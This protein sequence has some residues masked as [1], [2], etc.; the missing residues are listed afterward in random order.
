MLQPRIETMNAEKLGKLQI[1]RLKKI[2]RKVFRRQRFYREKMR[3]LGLKPSDIRDKKDLSK[4]PF[5]LKN[6]LRTSYP[7][8]AIV[9]SRDR[10]LELHASSGT[11]GKPTLIA[12]TFKDL[13]NWSELMARSLAAA[14]VTKNDVIHVSY[15]YHMF[16]GG[17]GFHYG[18][19]KLGA[20]VIPAGTGGS[21]RQVKMIVDFGATVLASVPNYALRLAEVAGDMGIDPIHDTKVRKGVFGAEPW[22]NEMRMRIE[23]AW[24]MDAR[25]MYGLSELYGPGVAV[26]CGEKE[27]L[28]VWEDHYLAEVVDPKTGEPVEPEEWGVLVIT[29]LTHDALPLIRYWTGDITRFLDIGKCGCGRTHRKIDRVKGRVDDMLIIN[30]L[31]VYPSA[32]ESI[33]LREDWAS[34]VFIIEVGKNGHMDRGRLIVESRRILDASEAEVLAKKLA[35]RLRENLLVSFHVKVVNP[36]ALTVNWGGKMRRVVKTEA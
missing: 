9:V 1:L 19:L 18:G 17:L 25:D 28:H 33:V 13:R 10:V 8:N 27:G 15:N 31:N 35:A 30:G 34:N 14:G 26:E 22:S 2:L 11:T 24:D 4:L 12:Y 16:T 21:E 7:Y 29:T 23:K 32:V 6:D 3:S 36:G 20:A 5:T